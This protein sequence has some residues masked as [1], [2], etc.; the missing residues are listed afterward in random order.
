MAARRAVQSGFS[1]ITDA[2]GDPA[3]EAIVGALSDGKAMPAGELAASA[4]ISPQSA[5][6]HLQK[7]VDARVLSVWSQ[8]RFRYYRISDDDVASLIEKL[9]DFAAKSQA[10]AHQRARVPEP[11]RQSRSC[12]GHLAG[13][14]GVA[15]G[16][17]LIHQKFVVLSGRSGQVTAAGL[18]WCR[19]EGIA[20]APSRAPHLRLC[21][22][23]IERVPHLA[24][25]FPNAILAHLSTT[26]CVVPRDIPR[27]LRLTPRGRAFFRRLGADLPF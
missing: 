25:P 2:L 22:D 3:R 19:A 17:A 18:D 12:F 7:L 21:N 14:L 4:G 26:R 23:W 13:L 20:F 24:G 8:G 16:K 15:L 1:R 9:A 27:A 5:S 11:L 6:A 10:A